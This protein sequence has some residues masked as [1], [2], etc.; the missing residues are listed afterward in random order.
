M[1]VVLDNTT[2]QIDISFCLP[3][4]NIENY[5]I[6][7][8]ESILKQNLQGI[9]YEVLCIDDCSTDKSLEICVSLKKR[10]M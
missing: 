8:I 7:C 6:E 2:K 10:L 4:Y 3:I 1:S 9:T 5:L